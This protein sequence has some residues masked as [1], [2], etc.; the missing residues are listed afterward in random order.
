ME[1]DEYSA[2]A[3]DAAEDL[4]G[5]HHTLSLPLSAIVWVDTVEGFSHCLDSICKVNNTVLTC[6]GIYII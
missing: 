2:A 5:N 6:H 3:A 1:S 4:H